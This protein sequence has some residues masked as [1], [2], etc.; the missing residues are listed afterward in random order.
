MPSSAAALAMLPLFAHAEHQMTVAGHRG[1]SATAPENTVPS[2]QL[3]FEIGADGVEWDIYKSAD[4]E[5]FVLHDSTLHRTASPTCPDALCGSTDGM[6]QT[7]YKDLL[8]Q[9]VQTLSYKDFI[10]YVDVGAWKASEYAGVRSPRLS[11]V[12]REVHSGKY[13][14]CEIKGSSSGTAQAVVELTAAEGWSEDRIRFIGFSYD[15]MKEIKGSLLS[16]GFGHN[17]YYIRS[18]KSELQA[19]EAIASASAGGLDGVDFNSV[20]SV[21]DAVARAAHGAPMPNHLGK[22]CCENGNCNQSSQFGTYV[23]FAECQQRCDEDSG[24]LAV[25]YGTSPSRCEAFDSC[26][27]WIVTG[28]C[29]SQ[30]ANSN[31]DIYLKTQ[32]ADHYG[33]ECCSQGNCDQSSKLGS[34]SSLDECMSRCDEKGDACIGVEYG[35]SRGDSWDRCA[36]LGLCDCYLVDG[37]CS[38]GSGHL[39]FN[40]YLKEA[41]P[42]RGQQTNMT[43]GLWAGPDSADVVS[44]F[45]L[46]HA[47]FFTSNLPD[48]VVDWMKMTGRAAADFTLVV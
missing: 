10:Q 32:P 16:R 47:D 6:S 27:C 19:F 9:N 2:M 41:T 18:V 38:E 35:N 45:D 15:L 29:S 25:E 13:A 8:T 11:E 43:L 3:A 22:E 21:T 34:S 12:M 24:C 44:S 30:S 37:Q 31:Y 40:V 17:V 14:L 48:D 23:S 7:E 20:G 36:S 4:G 1:A 5:L 42:Q 39:G 26:R 33:M 28:A 46:M